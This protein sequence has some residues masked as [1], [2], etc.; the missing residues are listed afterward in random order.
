MRVYKLAP[1]NFKAW[2]ASIDK[3]PEAIQTALDLY[4]DHVDES[5]G[6]EALLYELLL[7]SG[8][9]LT[10]QVSAITIADLTVYN[11]EDGALM[12]CLEQALTQAVIEGIAAL[13]PLRVICL[14]EGFRSNDQLK[15][16]AV[17]IMQSA[18]VVKF[19][20]V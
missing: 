8:F 3:T 6:Q 10:T 9:P 12:I 18:G 11:I 14:D 7:K 13:R 4:V 17:K 20:S 15:T 19:F 5:H 16:N 2:D 1:S